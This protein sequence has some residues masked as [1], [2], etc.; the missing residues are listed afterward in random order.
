MLLP[1]SHQQQQAGAAE[2]AWLSVHLHRYLD[3]IGRWL[4][5]FDLNVD[6]IRGACLRGLCHLGLF[7][8]AATTAKL[9]K[10]EDATHHTSHRLSPYDALNV[11]RNVPSNTPRG[12]CRGNL[13][14]NGHHVKYWNWPHTHTHTVSIAHT[15]VNSMLTRVWY[16][17]TYIGA[18]GTV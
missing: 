11:Q 1:K 14:D 17:Y 15:S 12:G 10:H 5:C 6:V 4:H 13:Q 8:S 7:R 16:H 9:A 3:I 2:G 18:Q